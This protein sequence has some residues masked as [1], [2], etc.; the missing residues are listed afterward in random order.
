MMGRVASRFADHCIVTSDNPRSESPD[1]IVAE[2]VA[3]MTKGSRE[4]VIDRGE[5]IAR[6]IGRATKYDTVLIAGKGHEDYQEIG[7]VKHP[8]SDAEV[9]RQ[10]LLAWR[11]AE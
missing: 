8:F 6:A 10:G 7:G 2:I 3:G 5:A 9:A 4:I 1:A 11:A